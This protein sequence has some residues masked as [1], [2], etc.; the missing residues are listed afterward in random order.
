MR[1]GCAEL[2]RHAVRLVT[3]LKISRAEI[4]APVMQLL[5][6]QTEAEFAGILSTD[7]LPS[8]EFR[9]W[10]PSHSYSG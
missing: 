10:Q 6:P 1:G 5:R 4:D 9:R 2:A 7:Y 8:D 3:R